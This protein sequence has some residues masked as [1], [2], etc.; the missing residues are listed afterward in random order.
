MSKSVNVWQRNY[1][2]DIWS[3]TQNKDTHSSRCWA[4]FIVVVGFKS[5]QGEESEKYSFLF[6]VIIAV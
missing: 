1:N 2:E 3:Y 6:V 5:N 4:L